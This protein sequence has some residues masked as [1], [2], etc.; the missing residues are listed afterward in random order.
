MEGAEKH[1]SD[2]N[3]DKD[4]L[5]E[6]ILDTAEKVI[7]LLQDEYQIESGDVI[8]DT[9]NLSITLTILEFTFSIEEFNLMR[10][11]IHKEGVTLKYNASSQT[12]TITSQ[13]LA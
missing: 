3:A 7:N 11:R 1:I 2:F 12:I 4:I 10:E 9:K 6:S 8:Y 13:R 5:P